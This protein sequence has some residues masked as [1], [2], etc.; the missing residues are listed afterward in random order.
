[1][2]MRRIDRRAFAGG[3]GSLI[4]SAPGI[5][6]AQE[7][8]G[9]PSSWGAWKRIP[10]IVV[11][12]EEDD[13]RL[14]AV[15]EAVAF[16]NA[17]FV[18]LA[19]PFRLGAVTHI[20]EVI[21]HQYVRPYPERTDAELAELF[22]WNTGYY[23]LPARIARASGDVVVV[24]SNGSSSFATGRRSPRKVMIVIKKYFPHPFNTFHV[25]RNVIAHELGHAIG[26]GHNGDPAALM[27]GNAWCNL[28]SLLDGFLPLTKAD[29]AKVLQMYPPDW[30]EE[31]TQRQWKGDPPAGQRLG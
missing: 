15:H 19:S 28:R 12:S 3:L 7:R 20:A 8:E 18:N 17:V 2:G 22:D 6:S 31:E 5:C 25:V 13:T 10:S 16:W 4:V 29:E 27:C 14:P 23:D 11:M 9:A 24:L 30:Q 21:P 1:V 26:L